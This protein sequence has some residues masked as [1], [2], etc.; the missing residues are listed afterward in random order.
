MHGAY[1]AECQS[2]KMCPLSSNLTFYDLLAQF[3]NHL[4]GLQFN[5]R[6]EGGHTLSYHQHQKKSCHVRHLTRHHRQISGQ[7]LHTIGLSIGQI[8]LIASTVVR[9]PEKGVNNVKRAMSNTKEELL[10]R[11]IDT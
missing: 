3:P 5:N 7:T 2:N 9:K 6:E 11:Y 10:H 4:Q 1:S 8:I